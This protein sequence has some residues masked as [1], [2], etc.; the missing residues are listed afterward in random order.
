MKSKLILPFLALSV[1]VF[2]GLTCPDN[3]ETTDP[4]PAVDRIDITVLTTDPAT[5]RVVG[6]V[7]NKGGGTFDSSTGQQSVQLWEG[8][9]L[10]ATQEFEDL[11]AGA[12][13]SVTHDMSWSTSTEFPPTLRVLIAY[14]P[15]IYI[16][17]N[18]NNDDCSTSDNVMEKTG[19]EINA[20]F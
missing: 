11:A 14:D 3:C 15:D 18:D 10:L 17:G 4:N 12:T 16:D 20:E 2:S 8:T 6:V 13:V 19:S 9:T 7:E 5:I 1:C